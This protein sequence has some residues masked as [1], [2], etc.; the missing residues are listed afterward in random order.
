MILIFVVVEGLLTKGSSLQIAFHVKANEIVMYVVS[1]QEKHV[2]GAKKRPALPCYLKKIS[3][4]KK[5][6]N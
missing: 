2:A 6:S 3:L 5:K 4:C 1:L